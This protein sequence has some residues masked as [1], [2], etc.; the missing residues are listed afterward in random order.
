MK[1][2]SKD[3]DGD[4][5]CGG[6]ACRAARRCLFPTKKEFGYAIVDK[7]GEPYYPRYPGVLIWGDLERADSEAE[8]MNG[9]GDDGPYPGAPYRA[10]RLLIEEIDEEVLQ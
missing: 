2:C 1:T 4:G 5:N 7:N 10:V 3:A 8:C 9:C 6:P